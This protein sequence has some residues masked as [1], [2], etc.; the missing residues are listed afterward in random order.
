MSFA[1]YNSKKM[2]KRFKLT[3]Y[4]NIIVHKDAF[5]CNLV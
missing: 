5:T 3:N 4:A 1:Y 2:V